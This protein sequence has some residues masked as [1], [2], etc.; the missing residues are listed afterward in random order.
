MKALA[1]QLQLLLALEMGVIEMEFTRK[2][3]N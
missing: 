3:T 2:Q 1:G